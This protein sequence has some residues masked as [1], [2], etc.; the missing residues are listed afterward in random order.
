MINFF[1]MVRRLV[2]LYVAMFL[3]Q[4]NWYQVILFMLMSLVSLAYIGY[5]HSFKAKQENYLFSF[6]EAITLVLA[7]LIMVLNGLC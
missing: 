6:N 5:N 7:Y 4:N 1:V 3:A 2:L